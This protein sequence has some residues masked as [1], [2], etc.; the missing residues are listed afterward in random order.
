MGSAATHS[1]NSWSAWGRALL[2]TSTCS[3]DQ[4]W[5]GCPPPGKSLCRD[6][7]ADSLH[8]DRE[9]RHSKRETAVA[10]REGL[11]RSQES[12]RKR[13]R[14]RGA[15]LGRNSWHPGNDPEAI[16]R[17]SMQGSVHTC[18]REGDRAD[19]RD[20]NYPAGGDFH[21]STGGSCW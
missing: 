2:K 14:A 3:C 13:K 1:T 20:T 7:A 15:M 8:L 18:H 19:V 12:F 16:T 17:R 11:Q 21:R 10:D 9:R 6:K 4:P 5:S